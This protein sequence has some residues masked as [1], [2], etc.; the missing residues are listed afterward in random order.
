[1][2]KV[3][4]S[5]L[6]TGAL[7]RD[8]TANREYRTAP[9]KINDKIIES[10]F[11]TSVLTE[12]LACDK[13]IIIG[14]MKSMWE[15]VYRR[16]A[17]LNDKFDEDTF[18]EIAETAEEANHESEIDYSILS[19]VEDAFLTNSKVILIKYGLNEAE[20][21]Y[22]FK[23]ILKIEEFLEKGDELH[24]DITHSFRSLS[25]FMMTALY[26]LQDVSEKKLKVEGLYYGMLDIIKEVGYAPI[27]NM[28]YLTDTMEWIKGAYTFQNFGNGHLI[29]KL[30]REKGEDILSKKITNLS[31]AFGI[32]YASNVKS[33]LDN[34]DKLNL[35]HLDVPESLIVP[36]VLENFKSQFKNYKKDSHFQIEL[37]EWY[38]DNQMYDSAYILLAEALITS[39]CEE[40][41][42][43]DVS[44]FSVRK[45]AQS[46]LKNGYG[47]IDKTWFNTI[48]QIRNDIAHASI[49]KRNSI[50]SD[51]TQLKN[52]INKAKHIIYKL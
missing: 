11:V 21:Q 45:D 32:N 17:K 30:L 33:Q 4:I 19:K 20:L 31:N 37:A 24:I 7:N 46:K 1:M 52:R 39:V 18:Y 12:E 35:K 28:K 5:F 13:V 51:I 47:I 49:G 10:S 29:S 34:L 36:K 44:T 41:G 9:Y 8:N 23:T 38:Y 25:I 50:L 43:S 16:Y 6:G 22:N 14:T 3:L 27:I 2:A 15:E 42:V 40:D 48:N 26:Y